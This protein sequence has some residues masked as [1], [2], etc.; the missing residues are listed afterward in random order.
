MFYV[1]PCENHT[2]HQE[3]AL[4]HHHLQTTSEDHRLPTME[5]ML[6][7]GIPITYLFST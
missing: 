1:Y 3:H 7:I 4:A 5:Y 2:L 6:V